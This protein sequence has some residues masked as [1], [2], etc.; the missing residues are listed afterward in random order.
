MKVNFKQANKP[1]HCEIKDKESKISK[2]SALFP[3]QIWNFNVMING[4]RSNQNETMPLHQ[5]IDQYCDIKTI[6]GNPS[7]YKQGWR[8][9]NFL[10]LCKIVKYSKQGGGKKTFA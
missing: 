3:I 1:N 2:D 8:G 4:E 7:R 9:T 6:V 10:L 5:I